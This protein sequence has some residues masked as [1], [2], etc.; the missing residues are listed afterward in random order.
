MPR[1][2]YGKRKRRPRRFRRRKKTFSKKLLRDAKRPGVNSVAERAVALIAK[3][4]A[5]KL[6][7]PN[8]IFR[9]MIWARYDRPTN[10][11]D[12]QTMTRIGWTGLTLLLPRIP[13][14]DASMLAVAG[15][16]QP[17]VPDNQLQ[18]QFSP[19]IYGQN[20]VA[21]FR[22]GQDGFRQGTK[23]RINNI[24][25]GIRVRNDPYGYSDVNPNNIQ[26]KYEHAFVKWAIVVVKQDGSLAA[27]AKPVPNRVL[28]MRTFGYTPRLDLG[29]DLATDHFK[30]RT[31]MKGTIKCNYSDDHVCETQRE[32]FRNVK[33][34]I[35][36]AAND[37]YGEQQIGRNALYL[38]CRCNITDPTGNEYDWRPK[39]GGYYKLGY[40]D[41]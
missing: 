17:Q 19:T 7:P 9:Q 22:T 10:N 11:M 40:K 38:V 35:Q 5:K 30:F 13:M 32:Y 36:Y 41:I 34:P 28:R 1:R 24:A 39:I 16:V 4:E 18:P 23:V 2:R 27:G 26:P 3:K 6:L 29:D 15:G 12:P 33:I 25:F 37:T 31:L 8:R 14:Q 21:P 20:V